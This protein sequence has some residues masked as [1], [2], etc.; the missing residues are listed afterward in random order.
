MAF[1][2]GK[3]EGKLDDKGRVMLPSI[4]RKH[5]AENDRE[6]IICRFDSDL[7]C[8]ILYPLSVWEKE[9]EL[10]QE[11]FDYH[12]KEDKSILQQYFASSEYL[13]IDSVGRILLN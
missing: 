10:V 8:L 3:N 13:D 7:C 6:Q 9:S 12:K 11:K 4:Y 2:I 1:F 5:L